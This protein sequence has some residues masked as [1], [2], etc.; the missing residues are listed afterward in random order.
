MARQHLHGFG[1]FFFVTGVFLLLLAGAIGLTADEKL[2]VLVAG[3]MI[4]FAVAG[5]ICFVAAAITLRTSADAPRPPAA[6]ARGK[7]EPVRKEE[8]PETPGDARPEQFISK[9]GGKL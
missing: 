2:Q 3:A 4:A 7:E 9:P 8:W 5:S 1:A 6:G